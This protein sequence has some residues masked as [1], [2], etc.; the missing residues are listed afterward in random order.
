MDRFVRQK[1]L[2]EVGEDGQA[3]LLAAEHRVAG[4]DGAATER[5]YLVRAGFRAVTEDA[6]A[7]PLTLPA[8]AEYRSRFFA[9]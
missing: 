9:D 7:E 8:F 4:T 5:A 3:R 1:R 2:A 6:L